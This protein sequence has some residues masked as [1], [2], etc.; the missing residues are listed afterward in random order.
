MNI[1]TTHI[2]SRRI[3]ERIAESE[4]HLNFT[5][6]IEII[7]CSC[8]EENRMC[9]DKFTISCF[10]RVSEISNEYQTLSCVYALSTHTHTH[11]RAGEDTHT[12]TPELGIP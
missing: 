5:A 10:R 6:F 8:I 3:I 11:I 4:G 1:V 2:Y 9:T 7:K 12:H